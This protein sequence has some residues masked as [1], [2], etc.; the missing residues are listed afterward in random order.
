MYTWTHTGTLVDHQQPTD[1]NESQRQSR[2]SSMSFPSDTPPQ[3]RKVMKSHPLSANGAGARESTSSLPPMSHFLDNKPS[4]DTFI[5]KR[6]ECNSILHLFGAWLFEAAL[7]GC[8]LH[9]G[10]DKVPSQPRRITFA[11]GLSMA[12]AAT[13]V[14]Y[15][16]TNQPITANLVGM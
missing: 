15:N 8:K 14:A 1:G 13:T 6:S 3:V 5:P 11:Y 4:E 9:K 10:E 16:I 2:V 12:N 7:T